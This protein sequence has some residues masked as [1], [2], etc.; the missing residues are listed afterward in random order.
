MVNVEIPDFVGHERFEEDEVSLPL[1]RRLAALLDLE[2]SGLRAGDDLPLP[3][4]AI[5]FP[6]LALQ[7]EIGP[8]GH[9][10]KGDFIPDIA[11]PKRMFAGRTITQVRPLKIGGSVRRRSTI[12]DVQPKQGRSGPLVFLT[13]L[14][15]ISGTDGLAYTERQEVV[16]RSEGSATRPAAPEALPSPEWEAIFRPGPVDLFRYSALTYNGHRIHYDQPYA[17]GAEGYPG[18]VVNGGLTTLKLLEFARTHLCEPLVEYQVRAVSALFDGQE[19]ALRGARTEDGALFWATRAEAENSP[20]MKI[21]I[22]T[23]E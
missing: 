17:T 9:P 11:L 8:D 1:C 18:L 6:T 3:W 7:S 19:I 10:R 16:Y 5:L 23:C 13:I 15:E 20:A 14:H 22:R 4:T 12:A 2:P 21:K